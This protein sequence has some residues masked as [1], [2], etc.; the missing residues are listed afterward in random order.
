MQIKRLDHSALVVADLDRTRWFY[1]H[2]LGLEE[3]ARPSTFSFG[4]CWFRGQGFE[5]HCILERDTTA[6]AGFGQPGLGA[7]TGLAHH[8]GFEVDDVGAV[9]ARLRA[10]GAAIVAGPMQR[11]DGIVQLYVNDPDGNFI[12]FFMH[13]PGSTLPQFERAPVR[14]RGAP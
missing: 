6:P 7:N 13:A 11:G 4:G 3:I 2:V 5:L 12:E 10:H 9:E 8:L 1:S 14:E